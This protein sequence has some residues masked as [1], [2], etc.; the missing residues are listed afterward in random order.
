MLAQRNPYI[1]SCPDEVYADEWLGWDD[2]LNGPIETLEMHRDPN[3]KRGRW[4]AGPLRDMPREES[5]EE[6]ESGGGG[7]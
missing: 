5:D 3:Y 6:E 2:F 1:P 7:A 4:L